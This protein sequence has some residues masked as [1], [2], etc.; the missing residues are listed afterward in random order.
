M[1]SRSLGHRAPLL[2]VLLPLMSGLVAAKLQWLP[3]SPVWWMSAALVSISLALG[4]RRA[5]APGVVLGIFLSGGALYEIRRDRLPDWDSLPPREI[6]AT[7]EIDRVFPPKPEMRSLGGLGR[8]VSTD[9]HLAELAGQPVYFSLGLK[10]GEAPPLRS[11]RLDI[12]GVLQTLPRNPAIDTF[13][14]YLASQGM[15]FKLTRARMNAEV[16]KAGVYQVFCDTALRRFNS[17]LGRGIETHPEQAGVLRAML[18]GQQQELND[19]QKTIFRES[20]TMHLFS[21]SGLHIAVIAAVIQGILILVRLPSLARVVVGGILLWLYV[22]ITGGTPSAVRA[23]LMVMFVHASHTLRV[24]GNPFAAL[25][26]SAVCVLLW[27]PMQLF[28][29]SFQLSYGIVAALL[30]LGLPMG[31]YCVEKWMLFPHLPKVTWRWYHH[32]VDYCW[33]GLLGLVAIGLST[34][35]VSMISGVVIFQLFTPISLP[36]NLVLIP[37]GSL[38]IISGFLSLLCGLIGIG[39]LSVLLNHA[40]T[41]LMMVIERGVRFFVD[42]PG[43]SHA[44]QFSP[45]WLGYAAF[46]GLLA[47]IVMGYALDWRRACGGFWTP[48]AF[49]LLVL[50]AGMKLI[51]AA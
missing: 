41:L 14:G 1:T 10:R 25:V 32:W 45:V 18:L 51:A 28:T 13:D 6:R 17:I 33:R 7:L 20:G 26:A 31:D 19:T 9:T 50:L 40:S 37:L 8:L 35:V 3:L 15:N 49:T 34:T 42:V 39:W 11:S 23:F 27:Q 5:W 43:A 24:P 2:W 36:A 30:L 46:A 44:A 12:T 38:V 16:G 29:A 21:I 22:D 4:W 48:F 47:L